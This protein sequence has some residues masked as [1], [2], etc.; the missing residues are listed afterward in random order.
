MPKV[1]YAAVSSIKPDRLQDAI[2]SARQA[3]KLVGRHGA[4]GRLLIADLAGEQTGT[5]IFVIQV[6]SVE[7]AA[8]LVASL[9]G[10]SEFTEFRVNLASSKSP[11]VPLSASMSVEIPL[12]GDLP[13]GRG[14]VIEVHITKVVPGRFDQSLAESA[15]A[16]ALMAKAG[17]VSIQAFQMLYAGIQTGSVGMAVEWSDTRSQVLSSSIWTT[18]PTGQELA[19]ASL[20]GTLASTLLSSAVY[21]DIPL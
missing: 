5:G 9:Q 18:D 10:D 20:N 11:I 1:S 7:S 2:E 8:D 19:A 15:K 4:E 14:S 3:N 6:D 16:G 17:A 12:P 13:Q 21:R